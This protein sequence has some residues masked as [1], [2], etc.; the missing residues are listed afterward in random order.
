MPTWNHRGKACFGSEM[1]DTIIFIHGVIHFGPKTGLSPCLK[2]VP[3]KKLSLYHN[4]DL[5]KNIVI[6]FLRI[7]R[8]FIKLKT[9]ISFTHGCIVSSLVK[10]EKN[11]IKL[12]FC[13]C[14]FISIS[15]GTLYLIWKNSIPV[16]QDFLCQVWLKLAQWFWN[17]IS[18][19]CIVEILSKLSPLE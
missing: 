17:Y 15:E 10:I 1:Y 9:K 19:A 12:H 3:I 16:T 2:P 14:V 6:S 4:V 8:S 18:A 13:Y 5:E 7:I 11:I